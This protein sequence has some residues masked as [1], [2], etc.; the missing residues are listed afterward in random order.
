MTRQTVSGPFAATR[1]QSGIWQLTT[2]LA[3]GPEIHL[4]GAG[5]E[6]SELLVL[7]SRVTV[8]WRSDGVL[9]ELSG[10]HGVRYL[11]A[12]GAI[13]HQPQSRLYDSLPLSSFDAAAQRFWRRV[14]LLIRLPGGRR[15][16]GLMTRR[17]R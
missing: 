4:L 15:L 8:E 14:F 2:E 13:I 7:V 16:L 9:V 6:A 11:K 10:V 1:L 17:N 5:P 3:S 12:R